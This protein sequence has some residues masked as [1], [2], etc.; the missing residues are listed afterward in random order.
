MMLLQP[1]MQTMA[2]VLDMYLLLE[3]TVAVG[4]WRIANI[5]GSD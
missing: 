3:V 4:V 1:A 5:G 2:D